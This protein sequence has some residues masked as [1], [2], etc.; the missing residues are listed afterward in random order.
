MF[1]EVLRADQLEDRVSQ[2]LEALIV[3]R[4]QVRAL[5]GE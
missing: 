4:R 5:V 1:V 3:A 2:V